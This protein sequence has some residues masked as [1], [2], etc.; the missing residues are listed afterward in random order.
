MLVR[1]P[2]WQERL[3]DFLH[4][5]REMPFA[6]GS[7]D[8]ALFA[9]DAVL[10]M[11]GTDLAEWFRL[12][13]YGTALDGAR[14]IREFTNGGTLADVASIMAGCFGIA[15]IKPSFAMLGDVVISEGP[16]GPML[17]IHGG[18]IA[19]FAGEFRLDERDTGE[20][21]QAWKI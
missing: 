9:C 18:D 11:T 4:D 17:G 16:A 1:F 5:R 7:N 20:C 14:R 19:W 21:L 3:T 13:P 10:A 2:D 6:W 15:E 12:H 8:C